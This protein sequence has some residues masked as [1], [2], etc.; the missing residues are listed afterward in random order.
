MRLLCRPH[1]G[2]GASAYRTWN[3]ALP[4]G[5]GLCPLQPPCREMHRAGGP[6]SEADLFVSALARDAAALVDTP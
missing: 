6:P 2:A 5:I 3:A 4:D 1:S